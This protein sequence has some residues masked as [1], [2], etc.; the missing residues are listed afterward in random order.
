VALGLGLV[1]GFVC[2]ACI[3]ALGRVLHGLLGLLD[4]VCR[5]LLLFFELL[6]DFLGQ[7]GVG[8]HAL[9][10]LGAGTAVGV[11]L[12][13]F[14]AFER[15]EC[16]LVRLLARLFAVVLDVG[17]VLHQAVEVLGDLV[18]SL[19]VFVVFLGLPGF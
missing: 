14:R 3:G 11:Q 8:A 5:F 12:L 7:L 9:G 18:E 6:H 13:F 17:L 15:V 1:Q 10:V 2:L 16:L 19:Q 4:R